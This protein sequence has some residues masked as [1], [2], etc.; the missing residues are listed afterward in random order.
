MSRLAF[1]QAGLSLLVAFALYAGV[2]GL[3]RWR[4]VLVCYEFYANMK[5]GSLVCSID[6]GH[7]LR[8]FGV[9][10]VK[11]AIARPLAMFY[12]PLRS[13]EAACRNTR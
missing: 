3:L 9:G 7:D 11:N 5:A 13:L 10:K 8:E 6:A 12:T 4:K 2:Y 1:R